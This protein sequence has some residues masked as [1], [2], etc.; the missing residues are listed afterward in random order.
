LKALQTVIVIA[1]AAADPP[2]GCSGGPLV[3]G[4]PFLWRCRITGPPSTPYENTGFELNVKF[5]PEY[6]LRPPEVK[7]ITKVYH[8]NIN[9]DGGVCLDILKDAWSP[10]LTIGKVL[11]SLSLLLAEA[12]PDT[13]LVADIA[14]Q[15]K[16]DRAG[17]NATA[18]EWSEK[19]GIKMT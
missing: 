19:Y 8:P 4:D 12:N 5:P 10:A 16:T 11:L 17:F 14:E 18:K 1:R 13:P 6:P 2:E 3:E 15:Y 9:A 7:F